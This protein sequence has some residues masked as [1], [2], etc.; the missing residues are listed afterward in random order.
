MNIESIA[1]T[2]RKAYPWLVLRSAVVFVCGLLACSARAADSAGSTQE[3]LASKRFRF[4]Y[5]KAANDK[6][7]PDRVGSV[8]FSKSRNGGRKI[9]QGFNY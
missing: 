5:G 1:P 3:R 4:G 2:I 9:P 6:M 7:V 8:E